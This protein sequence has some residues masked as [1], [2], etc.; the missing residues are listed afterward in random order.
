VLRALLLIYFITIIL[1]AAIAFIN[2]K[3]FDRAT[4][5]LSILLVIT[6][7]SEL[8]SRY[9]A[10]HYKN[11]NFIFHIFNV[12]ELYLLTLYFTE[13]LKIKSIK[14]IA[15]SAALIYPLLATLNCIYAQPISTLN[16]N[17][18]MFESFLVI[19]MSLYS[20]YKIFMN[21]SISVILKYPS[22]WFSTFLFLY[23]SCTFL[24]W[25]F[26][27]LLYIQKSNYY[28][29]AINLQLVLNIISYA[30]MGI[31]MLSFSKMIGNEH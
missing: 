3:R 31:T 22:F 10:V 1:A 28:D 12:I 20:L 18:I 4:K 26:I 29:W 27:K 17:F 13:A 9:C 2:Y 11:N 16:S 25:P 21:D 6:M 24:F 8:I 14:V 23:F 15:I 7:I 19:I 30:G 5:M